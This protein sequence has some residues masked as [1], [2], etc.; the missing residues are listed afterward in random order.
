MPG[1]AVGYEKIAIFLISWRNIK[2]SPTHL[3]IKDMDIVPVKKL[4]KKI[5]NALT[6]FSME[7]QFRWESKNIL[8]QW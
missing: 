5:E 1:K 2:F 3:G 4:C 6:G 7:V 8:M